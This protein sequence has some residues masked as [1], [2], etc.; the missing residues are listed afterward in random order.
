MAKDYYAILGVQK[1]ASQDEIKKA[2]RK[3]AHEHH[4]DKKGGNEARFKEISEAY[5]VLSDEKKRA[6]YDSFGSGF[7]SQG[8]GF[9]PNDF[10]GFDFSQFTNGQGGFEFDLGDIFGDFFGSGRGRA[11]RGSDISVDIDVTF[12]EA[13]FGVNKEIR[14]QK[15]GTCETCSGTGAKKGTQLDTCKA[16][17]GKGKLHEVR[18]SILGS[19]STVRTCETCG[20]SGKIPKENCEICKGK[21]I[22]K[23]DETINIE[24]PPGINNG[25]MIRMSGM[26][27]G[28]RGGNPGDLYIRVHVQKHPYFVKDGPHLRMNLKIKLTDT[29]LGASHTIETLDGRTTITIPE[30]ALHGDVIPI[31]GKGVPYTSNKRGDILITLIVQTPKKLSKDVKKI[32]EE[33]RDKGV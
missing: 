26:G 13:V 28:I 11:P 31:K 12:S 15:I 2:F 6:Q 30:G 22:H 27:E 7:S 3:L 24:I 4:P 9:N 16:C 23:Q 18:R 1:G 21:G 10:A 19:F 20:G 25:E 32:V 8:S 33:L 14:I 29:L 17:N 5:A